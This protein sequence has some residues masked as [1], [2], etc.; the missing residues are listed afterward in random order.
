MVGNS[1]DIVANADAQTLEAL[2][3][4][5]CT[6]CGECC[7]WPGWVPLYADDVERL[8][9]GLGLTPEAF[10]TRNCVVVWWK[11][12]DHPQFRIALAHKNGS[13][14]CVLLNGRSCSVHEFKPLKCKAGPADWYWIT[15]PRY[16]S[17]YVNMSPSFRHP[18]GTFGLD[19]ANQLFNATLEAER[20]ACKASSL[21]ALAAGIHVSEK[22]IRRLQLFEFKEDS[23]MSVNPSPNPDP[24]PGVKL[25][26]PSQ[27]VQKETA[28]V[29][30][31][32]SAVF[33]K[34]PQ[35]RI[36]RSR[37]PSK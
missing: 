21:A 23:T 9:R 19:E 25:T 4:H 36:S 32:N 29:L 26:Q 14:E 34:R 13:N 35:R 15:N 5:R 37:R 20:D 31:I 33:Q 2:S 12:D 8:A 11:W 3:R 30:P 27:E 10:L 22:F 17:Y 28:R 6:G 18:E 1:L 16:F 7:R 24:P